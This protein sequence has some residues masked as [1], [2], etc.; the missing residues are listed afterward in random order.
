MPGHDSK[1]HSSLLSK[2]SNQD[3]NIPKIVLD[4]YQ[5][6]RFICEDENLSRFMAE[7]RTR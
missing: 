4:N 5:K 3:F 7:A 2:I 6:I 1:L